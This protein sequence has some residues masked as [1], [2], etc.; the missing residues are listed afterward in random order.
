ML[1]IKV[2]LIHSIPIAHP[3]VINVSQKGPPPWLFLHLEIIETSQLGIVMA[4]SVDR[5]D[6]Q[7]HQVGI[8]YKLRDTCHFLYSSAFV[9]LCQSLSFLT[10]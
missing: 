8:S 3:M 5:R 2:F 4:M 10:T 7:C 9:L 1:K 6:Y